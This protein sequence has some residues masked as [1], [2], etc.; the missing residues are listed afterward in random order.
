ME[1]AHP[2]ILLQSPNSILSAM[3]QH[4]GKS[5][6]AMLR[7]IAEQVHKERYANEIP[8]YWG[9]SYVINHTFFLIFRRISNTGNHSVA[10]RLLNC[11][12]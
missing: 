6:S 10:T 7:K 4:T 8:N 2:H 11:R 5:S 9:K 12:P 1:Y 3:V